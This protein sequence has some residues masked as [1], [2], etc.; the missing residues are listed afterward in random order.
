LRILLVDDSRDF[1]SFLSKLLSRHGHDVTTAHGLAIAKV[2][3]QHGNFD[4]LI[5]DL[6]LPDGDG[7]E[8][9]AIATQDGAKAMALTGR[10]TDEEIARSLKAGFCAH[11]VKPVT[12]EQIIE[13]MNSEP[14]ASENP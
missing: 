6:G 14:C 11:L 2:I 13:A 4:L 5:C 1:T 10:S 8:L 12:Y 7:I 9:A 3:C